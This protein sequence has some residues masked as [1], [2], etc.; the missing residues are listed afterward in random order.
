MQLLTMKEKVLLIASFL[1]I[2]KF[3]GLNTVLAARFSE[4]K[5]KNPNSLH[6]WPADGVHL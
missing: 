6:Q 4:C 1:T 5:G 2:K 3:D